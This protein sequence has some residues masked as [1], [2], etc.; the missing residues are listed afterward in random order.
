MNDFNGSTKVCNFLQNIF[1]MSI[2]YEK[3]LQI[4]ACSFMFLCY[5]FQ[6]YNSA[7]FSSPFR[8]RNQNFIMSCVGEQVSVY[9]VVNFFIKSCK[10]LKTI[11]ILWCL[12]YLFHHWGQ[13]NRFVYN[14]INQ[15]FINEAK[16]CHMLKGTLSLDENF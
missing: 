3:L 12:N 14:S 5:T 9:Y 11:K 7:T 10:I 16:P 6:G 13:K 4:T 15:Y 2:D 8:F 1:H